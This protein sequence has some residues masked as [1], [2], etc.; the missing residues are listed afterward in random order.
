MKLASSSKTP[1]PQGHP[2]L[3]FL[4]SRKVYD[5][6]RSEWRLSDNTSCKMSEMADD[7]PPPE[8]PKES[9]TLNDKMCRYFSPDDSSVSMASP[10]NSSYVSRNIFTD[11]H[12][13]FLLQFCGGMVKSGVISQTV[14]QKLLN[15]EEEGR[16]MLQMFTLKQI[17][18]RLKYERRMNRK[19]NST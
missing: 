8:L 5:K 2:R 15:K 12:R 3:R 6:I 10:S 14:V 9:E 19:H 7:Q 17:I 1:L 11:E 16:E 13:K 4:D 18:N